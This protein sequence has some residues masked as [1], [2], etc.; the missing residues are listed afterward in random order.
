M[1]VDVEVDFMDLCVQ[2]SSLLKR[3]KAFKEVL[4]QEEIRNL[5]GYEIHT[6]EYHLVAA[7][8][9][10]LKQ[11]EKALSSAGVD[12]SR[13]ILYFSECVIVY[14]PVVESAV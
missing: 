12:F 13:P 5:G 8:L 2:K 11:L 14:M 10:D 9:R 1:C 3:H 7:D 6:G 4:P